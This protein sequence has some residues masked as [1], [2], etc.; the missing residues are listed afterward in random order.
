MCEL[1]V[2]FTATRKQV[3][4]S[5]KLKSTKPRQKSRFFA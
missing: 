1:L 3:L 4:S 5:A 2:Q